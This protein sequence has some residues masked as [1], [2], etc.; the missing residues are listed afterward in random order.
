MLLVGCNMPRNWGLIFTTVFR[1]GEKDDTHDA[2]IATGTENIRTLLMGASKIEGISIGG[3]HLDHSTI[4]LI[5]Y[6]NLL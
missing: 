6:S 1:G 3:Y 5:Y 4:L 2:D